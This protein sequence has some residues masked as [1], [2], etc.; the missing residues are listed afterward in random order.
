MS[1]NLAG[2]TALV[3]GAAV[4][5]GRGTALALARCG[6][7]VVVHYNKSLTMA[8]SLHDELIALGVK[9]WL[10]QADLSVESELSRLIPQVQ[11]IVGEFDILINNASIFPTDTLSDMTFD[12]VMQNMRVNAW[13]PYSLGRDFAEYCNSGN[14][15]NFLDARL[16]GYDWQHASYTLSKHT[17]AILTRMTA[18]EYAPN[19]RVNAVAPG[20]ILPPPG[21]DDS[22]MQPLIPLV[23]LG[24]HGTAEEIAQAVIYLLQ[25][26]FITGETIY[27]DGGRH[28]KEPS[29]GSN[30]Y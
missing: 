23:P 6:V 20:L 8:E 13:A 9:C 10:V 5:L 17:M 7:N 28:L 22:F 25:N 21:K 4:R 2:K 24:R 11:E 14:I 19:I 15:I 30:T 3:T 16:P 18:L 26:E 1:S 27:I 12:S 29:H